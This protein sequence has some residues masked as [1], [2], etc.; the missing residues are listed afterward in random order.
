MS[1]VIAHEDVHDEIADS[2]VA[3]A[4]SLLVGRGI[5]H[6]EFGANTGAMVSEPQRDRAEW[7]VEA[8]R[9]KS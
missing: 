7:L 4:E 5:E 8:Q 6:S 9:R 1:R 2:C 3:L